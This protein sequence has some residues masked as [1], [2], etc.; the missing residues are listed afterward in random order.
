VGTGVTRQ[1]SVDEGK[2]LKR[3]T[4]GNRGQRES[5][6]RVLSRRAWRVTPVCGNMKKTGILPV[7]D[8]NNERREG[9][10]TE[11]EK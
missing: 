1:S 11:N 3:S 5:Q 2:D 9:K 7:S 6:S 8:G 10:N 4:N